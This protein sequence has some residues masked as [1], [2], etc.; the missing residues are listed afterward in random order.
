M[1]VKKVRFTPAVDENGQKLYR[2]EL[3]ILQTLN[4][5]KRLTEDDNLAIYNLFLDEM[6]RDGV[7]VPRKIKSQGYNYVPEKGDLLPFALGKQVKRMGPGP[8]PAKLNDRYPKGSLG[9]VNY[10][11]QVVSRVEQLMEQL[12]KRG[13]IVDVTPSENIEIKGWF[14]VPLVFGIVMVLAGL[15]TLVFNPL[16][17]DFPLLA[18][19]L[20]VFGAAVLILVVCFGGKQPEPGWALTQEGLTCLEHAV[21][22]ARAGKGYVDAYMKPSVT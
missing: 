21:Q 8:V 19:S 7:L 22:Y 15:F 9:Y 10:V 4:S 20:M 13:L 17:L 18:L 14:R 5:S 16:L 11:S 3:R 1:S 2:F 6:E 12:E